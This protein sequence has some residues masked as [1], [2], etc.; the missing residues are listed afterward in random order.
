MSLVQPPLCH[1]LWQIINKYR[2][3]VSNDVTS[4]RTEAPLSHR[5]I[6]RR[7]CNNNVWE[8][9]LK[10]CSYKQTYHKETR[11]ELHQILIFLYYICLA[12]SI[13]TLS[14]FCIAWVLFSVSTLEVLFSVLFLVTTD[15]PQVE[16]P[17]LAKSI[18]FLPL[19]VFPFFSNS[20]LEAIVLAFSA[21]IHLLLTEKR[22]EYKQYWEGFRFLF[23][24]SLLGFLSF[25][26]FCFSAFGR[27]PGR[28]VN[29][30]M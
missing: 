16:L 5:I 10:L 25:L 30:T 13:E 2:F 4:M 14:W 26:F 15:S 24:F 20:F 12:D 6:K 23:F 19:S 28:I 9:Y 18:I 11:K 22:T 8:N 27:S 29:Y 21:T 17:R 1:S 3:Y 7:E